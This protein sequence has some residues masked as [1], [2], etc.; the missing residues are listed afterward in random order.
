MN[1]DYWLELQIFKYLQTHQ[2]AGDTLEGI[3]KWWLMSKRIDESVIRVKRSLDN[4]KSK[5]V[6]R[7]RQ[8][9]DGKLFYVLNEFGIGERNTQA[10]VIAFPIVNEFAAKEKQASDDNTLQVSRFCS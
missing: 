7:E 2:Q 10:A 3:A 5:G 6:V 4:L 1:K 9:A 8:L